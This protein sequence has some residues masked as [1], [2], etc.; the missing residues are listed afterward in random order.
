MELEFERDHLHGYETVLDTTLCQEETMESIVPDACPDIQRVVDCCGQAFLSGKLIR[1]GLASVSGV[2]RVS[3]LYQP[4]GEAGGL[5]RM[6]L[7]LPFTCQAEAAGLTEAGILLASPRLRW[8]EARILNPRKVLLR[9]ELAVDLTACQPQDQSVCGS[10]LDPEVHSVCQMATQQESYQLSA[11]QERPFSFGEQ[12]RLPGDALQ[13]LSCRVTPVCT[14]SKLIGTKLIF[15]G[16]V[17]VQL[18]LQSSEGAL[19]AHREPLTFS[20]VMEVAGVGEEGDC[21]VTV[22]LN[23]LTWELSSDGGQSLDMSLDLLAQAQVWNRRPMTMLQDLYSTLWN[24][25]VQIGQQPVRQ[26]VEQSVRPQSVRELLESGMLVRSVVDSWLSVGEVT[27]SREG[28][29]MVLTARPRLSVLCLD[30]EDQP[31][32]IHKE[33][34]VTCRLDCPEGAVCFCRCLCPGE[35][36]AAPASGGLEVRFTLEFHCMALLERKIPAVTGGRLTEERAHGGEDRPSM[37]LR[38]AA[39]G[40]DL[41]DIAKAYGTTMEEIRQ[42][43]ELEEGALPG[44]TMLLIPRAR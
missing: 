32:T 16:S 26:L 5:R 23:D 35:V 29:Q 13:V 27:R 11:V 40:E 9:V 25:E 19:S 4:E 6:E 31:Q 3:L 36:F 38:L 30:E 28:E 8:A 33:L 17:D 10:V 18:L 41:W 39:P 34:E 43:N 21:H 2:I 37:V 42:A 24:T 14:E 1:D 12:I 20:Q 44:N 7:S 22:E 15:K